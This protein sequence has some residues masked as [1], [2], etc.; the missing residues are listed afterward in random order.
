MRYWYFIGL[1]LTLMFF[2]PLDSKGQNEL[3]SAEELVLLVPE[4]SEWTVFKLQNSLSKIPG[5]HLSGY[6]R[7]QSCLLIR[8]EEKIIKSE[9]IVYAIEGIA[10]IRDRISVVVGC[11]FYEVVDGQMASIGMNASNLLTTTED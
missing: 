8:F 5:V 4:L 7:E 1:C 10:N 11:N 3:K 6:C 9:Q 2:R